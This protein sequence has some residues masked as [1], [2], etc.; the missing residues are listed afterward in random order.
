M[1]KLA[2]DFDGTIVD[3]N[4]IKSVLIQERF[5][6]EIPAWQ[7][8]RTL[9][10]PQIGEAA[11]REIAGIVYERES[12][13]RTPPLSQ[14]LDLIPSLAAEVELYLLTARPLQ[15][16]VY[17]EEWLEQYQIRSYFQQLLSS[18]LVER[19]WRPKLEICQAQGFDLLLDD[20]ASHVETPEFPRITKVLLKDGCPASL[21]PPKYAR[22]VCSWE[23]FYQFYREVFRTR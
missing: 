5:G 11:Y 18:H 3:T 6:L 21:E 17:A 8:D 4:L 23:D 19:T 9:C 13:L 20:D 2:L 15:R 16:L 7:C 22:L 14:A 10:E 12:T 1:K